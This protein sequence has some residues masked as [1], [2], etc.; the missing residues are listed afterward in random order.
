MAYI[1]REA[2]E[3]VE[4]AGVVLPRGTVVHLCPAVINLSPSVWGPDA[5]TFNPDRWDHLEGEAA[6]TYAFQTFHNGPRVCIAK[7]MAIMEMKVMLVELMSRFRVEAI[8]EAVDDGAVELASPS[9]TLRS[10]EKLR[11]RLVED[12]GN[13][14]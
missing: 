7:Q 13:D 4:V 6:G 9:F 5:E 10:K 2:I 11:V 8:R 1:P 12:V 3:E 14:H